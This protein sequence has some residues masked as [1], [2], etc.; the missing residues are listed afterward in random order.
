MVHQ[1]STPR[2]T[3]C[4]VIHNRCRICLYGIKARRLRRRAHPRPAGSVTK[5]ADPDPDTA[6]GL[7][8]CSVGA[9]P[10]GQHPARGAP[11]T[12]SAQGSRDRFAARPCPRATGR[13][14][15]PGGSPSP[16]RSP[17]SS[18]AAPPASRPLPLSLRDGLRPALT[19]STRR[20]GGPGVRRRGA[21]RS[22]QAGQRRAISVPLR[23]VNHGQTRAPVTRPA[24]GRGPWPVVRRSLPNWLRGFDSRRPLHADPAV[25]LIV[26]A[27]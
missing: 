26:A 13:R 21:S 27:R 16:H 15:P 11:A 7:R 20:R 25:L 2:R 17:G 14:R 4:A 12:G 23:P 8:P 1:L 3:R 19:P 5:A 24:A 6:R 22:S 10:G 18:Y 9:R